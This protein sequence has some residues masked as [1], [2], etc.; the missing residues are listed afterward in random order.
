MIGIKNKCCKEYESKLKQYSGFRLPAR[1]RIDTKSDSET[2]PCRLVSNE[3]DPNF[4]QSQFQVFPHRSVSQSDKLDHICHISRLTEPHTIH[5]DMITL[6]SYLSNRCTLVCCQSR[7][8]VRRIFP[9]CF[10][11]HLPASLWREQIF[12]FFLFC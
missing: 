6:A 3:S 9:L 4:L 7:C 10:C 5:N 12:F 2:Y 8:D 1:Q 11:F